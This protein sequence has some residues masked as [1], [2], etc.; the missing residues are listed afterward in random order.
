MC[1]NPPCVKACPRDALTQAEDG[2]IIVDEGK[3]TGCGLCIEACDFGALTLHPIRRIPIVCDLCNGT[4]LCIE[5][6][7]ED[8]LNLTTR[9]L[10]AQVKRIKTAEKLSEGVL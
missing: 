4:P 2:R 8:A 9:D 3:C 7:P 6:C 1:E 10:L 5:A